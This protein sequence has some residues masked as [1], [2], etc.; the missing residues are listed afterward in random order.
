MGRVSGQLVLPSL[1]C[2]LLLDNG[3]G[4]IW[5]SLSPRF[6]PTVMRHLKSNLRK[7][8]LGF[9]NFFAM[10]FMRAYE[11]V[12]TSGPRDSC[13]SLCDSD[14]SLLCTEEGCKNEQEPKT[15]NDKWNAGLAE[16]QEISYIILAYG[17]S[18]TQEFRFRQRMTHVLRRLRVIKRFF[19][20]LNKPEIQP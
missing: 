8:A 17:M 4:F 5:C 3:T 14:G 1:Y 10:Y 7:K 15:K 16:P 19:L 20:W 9:S 12:L 18:S 6:I 11:Y 2:K 13:R